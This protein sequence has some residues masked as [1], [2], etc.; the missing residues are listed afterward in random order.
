MSPEKVVLAEITRPRGIRGEV[1]ARSLTDV[2]GRLEQLKSAH[3]E[4]ADG[5]D[6][7][8]ELAAAWKHK[9]E[10]VLKFSGV[11]S[12]E[13][14]ARLRGADLW[15]PLS[16]RG[17]LEADS[18]FQSDLIGCKVIDA[19]SGACI[20]L[21]E[22]WQEYGGPPLMEVGWDGRERL[23]PFVRQ[24]CQVDLAARTICAELPEGL[25]DL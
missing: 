11:D 7:V 21:V 20:G 1:V 3:L 22:G 23:I 2:A 18:F 4:L 16:E 25:L 6:Q 15:V 8:V 24:C 9:G 19:K 5:F 14:A 17:Q 10:W 12:P 13:A